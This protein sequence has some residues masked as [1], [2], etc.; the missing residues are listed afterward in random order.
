M[1]E[2]LRETHG[3]GFELLRHFLLHF[4]DS[5]LVTTSGQTG[6]ALAGAVSMFLPWFPLIEQPL[7]QKY[8]YFSHLA[9]PGPYRLAVRADELWLITLMMSAIGLL[10]A[11]KW[12]ALFPGLSDYRTLG[13]LPL[14]AR[15]IFAAKLSALFL[16]ATAAMVTLNLV[17]GLVFPSVSAG[18]WAFHADL[19][20]RLLAHATA[21]V[22]GCYFFFFGMV[23]LQGVLL[24]LLRPRQFARV[25]GILQGLLVAVMLVLIVLSFNIQPQVTAAVVRPGT[26]ALASAGVVPGALPEPVGRSRPGDAGAGAPCAHGTGDGDGVGAVDL[27]RQLSAPSRVSHGGRA[28]SPEEPAMGRRRLRLADSGSAPPGRD[29]VPCQDAG[30]Q[31]STSHHPDGLWRLWSSHLS[32]RNDRYAGHG[33]ARQGGGGGL[34]LR[35]HHPA[36]FPADRRAPPVLHSSGAQGQLGVPDHRTR[37]AAGMV[38]R[39]GP[40]RAG[41]GRPG[42]VDPA[43]SAGGS[44][45]RLARGWRVGS[46]RRI[47]HALLRN[48]LLHL[49]EA[50][51]HLL[52]PAGEDAGVAP[53]AVPARSSHRA[54]QVNWLLL[55]CLYHPALFAVALTVLLA[56]WARLHAAREE[57][58]GDL[59]LKY[60]ESPDPAI[61]GLNLLR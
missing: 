48:G 57:G 50:A 17:P 27:H 51:L 32:E 36:G 45:A 29:C 60:E 56:I 6:P 20:G 47:R 42:D 10:T 59:R 38:A 54:P 34:R 30:R 39:G 55:E 23:A 46:V 15:Q 28:R 14:R 58:W 4:F 19:G 41:S 13:S 35:P 44:S 9:V 49:G 25:T 22:A 43:I 26:R 18:R 21:A 12:Q 24:N 1:K 53:G 2:W 37:G 7:R 16:V 40:F 11:I 31:Q 52:A 61:H 33:G 3:P 5:D 8:A